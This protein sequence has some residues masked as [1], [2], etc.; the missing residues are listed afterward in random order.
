MAGTGV[1][2]GML[3]VVTDRQG[4]TPDVCRVMAAAAEAHLRTGVPI[5]T[6]THAPSRNGPRPA[7]V[8]RRARGGARAVGDR[9]LRRHRGPRLPSRADGRRAPPSAW[10]GSA[11][12]TS[13]PTTRGSRPCWPCW[14]RGTPTAWCSRTTRRSSAGSRRRP[15]GP[16]TRRTGTWRTCTGGSCRGSWPAARART[17]C[18]RCWWS[19]PP[20]CSPRTRGRVPMTMRTSIATVCISGTLVEKLHA[21]AEAGFDGVEIFEPDLVASPASPEEIAAL[22]QRLGLDRRPLPAVPRRRGGH[23]GR[24]R[25]GAAP[26]PGQVRADAAARRR[27]P[28]RLQQRR[29]RDDRRR[30]GLG[31]PAAPARRRGGRARRPAGLRGAGV[32]QVRRRLPAGLADRRAGGPPGRGH[33]PRQLPHPLPRPRPGRDRGDPGRQDLLPAAGRRPGAHHGRPVLEPAPPPVPGRGLL[34]PAGVRRSRP[35]RGLPRA[36]L[37]RGL[38]RHLP[39]DR[40]AAD[41][42]AGEALADLARGPGGPALDRR[43]PARRRRPGCRTSASP[44]ASTSSRSRP[45]TPARST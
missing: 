36:D 18:T 24:V 28:P 21:C 9:P 31:R 33:L 41:R 39:A 1:R 22:A 43:G 12:S 5:T 13:C 29:H 10:T 6:H 40:R 23:R 4:L 3:K 34:R 44:R 26:S 15:G 30:R 27:H 14:R 38:Q 42:A 8:L 19:T 37:A 32:G 11:W 20:G 35:P 7:A 16:R 2:A 17:T 45:R 25:R